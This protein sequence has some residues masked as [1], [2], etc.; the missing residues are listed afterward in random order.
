M[1][2]K[3]RPCY[4]ALILVALPILASAGAYSGSFRIVEYHLDQSAS[5]AWNLW[6]KPDLA[7]VIPSGCSNTAFYV[8]PM[9][10]EYSKERY[11][12]ILAAFSAGKRIEIYVSGCYGS[13]PNDYP[14]VDQSR[15]KISD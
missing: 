15:F 9:N 4:L 13:A 12:A 7:V 1:K 10:Y 11:S 8:L 3:I 14:S 2:M 6:I 5:G